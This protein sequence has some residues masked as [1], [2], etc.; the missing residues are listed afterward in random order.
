MKKHIRNRN[1]QMTLSGKGES[2]DFTP[3]KNEMVVS[4]DM[5]DAK[6]LN[7]LFGSSNTQEPLGPLAGR[8]NDS[9]KSIS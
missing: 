6:L 7:M 4:C 5:L 2:V 3:R 9:S 8:R 1:N